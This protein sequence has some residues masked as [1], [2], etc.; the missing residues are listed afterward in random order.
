[1]ARDRHAPPQPSMRDGVVIVTLG[2][3]LVTEG[4]ASSAPRQGVRGVPQP[5]TVGQ[6]EQA[7]SQTAEGSPTQHMDSFTMVGYNPDGTKRWDLKGLGASMED[8]VVTVLHPDAIGYD[9]TPVSGNA[10]SRTTYLTASLAQVN[11]ATRQVR[12][13]HEVTIHTSD[14]MWLT[15]PLMYWLPD[16]EELLTDQPVRLEGEHMLLRGR[17]ATGR[18]QLKMAVFLHDV[19]L[20]LNP[21]TDERPGEVSHV[22][23]TCDGPLAFDYERNIATFEQN[24]HIVDRQGELFS[25]KLIAYLEK[26]S[27]TISY[28]EAIGRVR[29]VQGTNTATG[30]RAIYEPAKNKVTLLGSPSLVVYPE[31]K[32][33]NQ[34]VLSALPAPQSETSRQAGL[35]LSKPKGPMEVFTAQAPDESHKLSF[36]SSATP[37]PR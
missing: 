32:T 10:L 17:G 29:I 13:E 30:E 6:G 16:Q 35:P 23:I 33:S 19:E 9:H 18:T 27:H 11:Q 25:D 26:T 15:S 12:L 14:G 3:L 20:V 8:Q 2:I 34:P 37:S 36:D 5:G 21:T 4:V 22:T 24:V 7:A 31:E 1:M 28:A